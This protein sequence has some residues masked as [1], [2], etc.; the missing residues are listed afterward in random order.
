[1][2]TTWW[3]SNHQY[4]VSMG[5]NIWVPDGSQTHVLPNTRWVPNPYNK[6]ESQINQ[7]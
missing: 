2:E 4:I 3:E 7:Q 1:M 5:K 6:L